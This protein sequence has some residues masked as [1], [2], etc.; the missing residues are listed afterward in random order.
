[1]F[2]KILDHKI[3][4]IS[5]SVIV[6]GVIIVGGYFVFR[7]QTQH[8]NTVPATVTD[9][10]ESVT[11]SGNIDSNQDVSLSFQKSGTVTAVNVAVGDHVYKGE[12]LAS[13]DNSDL[14]AQLQGGA[15]RRNGRHKPI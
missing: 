2:S 6:V 3:T 5:L 13:L 1:M 14:E 11:A 9:I 4:L 7:P 10:Q 8:F 12:T 15:S